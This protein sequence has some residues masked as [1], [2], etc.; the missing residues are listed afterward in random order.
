MSANQ[1]A[2]FWKWF[3][4]A[5]HTTGFSYSDSSFANEMDMQIQ[6]AFP[7][8]SWEIGPD[9]N[10]T[11]DLFLAISPCRSIERQQL[12]DMALLEAPLIPG[13]HLY[14]CKPVKKWNR[15]FLL[16]RDSPSETLV[17][18]DACQVSVEHTSY[19]VIIQVLFVEQLLT[20][21]Q[22]QM[23]ADILVESE[24]GEE[25]MIRQNVTVLG[26]TDRSVSSLWKPFAALKEWS[27]FKAG[28]RHEY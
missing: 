28:E 12:I 2:L 18:G 20:T 10:S 9:S 25:M 8:C 13:W 26:G 5:V 19:G 16:D 21:S 4:D 14:S 3:A 17:S 22:Q 23:A 15:Q 11:N 27:E 24:I 1:P 6:M 7:N